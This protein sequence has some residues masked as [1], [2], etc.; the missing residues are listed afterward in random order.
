MTDNFKRGMAFIVLMVILTGCDSN[1]VTQSGDSV[2]G[3]LVGSLQGT[4]S[5]TVTLSGQVS[6]AASG[7]GIPNATIRVEGLSDAF[8]RADG[9]YFTAAFLLSSVNSAASSSSNSASLKVTVTAE[10]IGYVTASRTIAMVKGM[11]SNLEFRLSKKLPADLSGFV[12]NSVTG[13]GAL[14]VTVTLGSGGTAFST[15]TSE[16]DVPGTFSFTGLTTGFHYISASGEGYVTK[17]MGLTLESG[18]NR[19]EISLD[20]VA[21]TSAV[22][23]GIITGSRDGRPISGAI[24]QVAGNSTA[25]GTGSGGTIQG[26]FSL[27]SLPTGFVHVTVSADGFQTDIFGVT[28]EKGSNIRNL[29]ISPE[30][31]NHIVRG[32]LIGTAVFSDTSKLIPGDKSEKKYGVIIIVGASAAGPGEFQAMTG[33]DGWYIIEGIPVGTHPVTATVIKGT[34]TAAE[35][36]DILTS[37]TIREGINVLNLL[38]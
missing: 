20:T 12:K 23:T 19:M 7:E 13:L 26:L 38:F 11:A 25:T 32:N 34:L 27:G 1:V 14:G 18:V 8:T 4:V 6:D 2:I 22:F 3:G 36:A 21:R 24:V 17:V 28:L 9:R 37:V 15:V 31:T 33:E 30:T 16:S 35:P 5:E 10:V 29:T